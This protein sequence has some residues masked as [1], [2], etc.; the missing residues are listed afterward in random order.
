MSRLR[1]RRR[2]RW[3]GLD[4]PCAALL[5]GLAAS[6]SAAAG[7]PEFAWRHGY[8][9]G[10]WTGETKNGAPHGEGVL[11]P[12][13][14]SSVPFRFEG[15]IRK[16]RWDG[17]W[18]VLEDS[19]YLCAGD[20]YRDHRVGLKKGHFRVEGGPCDAHPEWVFEGEGGVF[21]KNASKESGVMVMADGTHG[22][23]NVYYYWSMSGRLIFPEGREWRGAIST[24]GLAQ[25]FGELRD[26]TGTVSDVYMVDGVVTQPPE[27]CIEGDCR[28]EGVS[29]YSAASHPY[30][31]DGTWS[32]SHRWSGS[33]VAPEGEGV[34]T[35][36]DGREVERTY[37]LLRD[38]RMDAGDPLEGTYVPEGHYEGPVPG[39]AYFE[40]STEDAQWGHRWMVG[41]CV[42]TFSDGARVEADFRERVA[43]ITKVVG[44][45]AE[46]TGLPVPLSVAIRLRGL[47]EAFSFGNECIVAPCEPY[48]SGVRATSYSSKDLIWEGPTSPYGTSVRHDVAL[49]WEDG[50]TW[51][52]EGRDGVPNGL[53]I[54]CDAE[55]SCSE[56]LRFRGGTT[57]MTIDEIRAADAEDLAEQER[58]LALAA[59]KAEQRAEETAAWVAGAGEREQAD[60]QKRREAAAEVVL[61][62]LGLY[63]ES[64]KSAL[65]SM[66]ESNALSAWSL[67]SVEDARWMAGNGD[68]DGALSSRKEGVFLL[69]Q[70]G[71][72]TEMAGLHF[73]D[74]AT[75]ASDIREAVASTDCSSEAVD[76]FVGEAASMRRLGELLIRFGRGDMS[77]AEEGSRASAAM[78][79]VAIDEAGIR[80]AK[81]VQALARGRCR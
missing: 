38:D 53:G 12:S 36:A 52:G 22:D 60:L 17:V 46:E 65:W 37:E 44:L 34:W 11:E 67:E 79:L 64:M 49:A 32:G 57:R 63:D 23:I 20:R 10:T 9:D 75:Y 28:F 74:A 39:G 56:Q 6:A 13:P 16:D 78:N 76:T 80:V 73:V 31:R 33:S 69:D 29:R 41:P 19:A 47:Q 51:V 58:G 21:G 15:T 2:A 7:D 27:E 66:R 3:I 81:Q 30:H 26:A 54:A 55:G 35:Y 45:D 8:P 1:S 77:V 40:G 68:R 18:V 25:G 72:M 43:H 50:R 4:L 42:L 71:G 48:L 14:D 5:V 61:Q 62:R 59:R 70:A 24:N